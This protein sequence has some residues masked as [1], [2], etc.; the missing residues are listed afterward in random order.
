LILA[1]QPCSN[2]EMIAMHIAW[3]LDY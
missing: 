2:Y 3:Y 1:L